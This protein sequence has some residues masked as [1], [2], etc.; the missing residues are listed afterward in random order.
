MSS[1]SHYAMTKAK[2]DDERTTNVLGA[3]AI[4]GPGLAGA[5]LVGGLLGEAP[6]DRELG[7]TPIGSDPWLVR[8]VKMAIA[9]VAGGASAAVSAK[10]AV[11]T[12]SG[13]GTQSTAL[14]AAARTVQG[15]K[16]LHVLS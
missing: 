5:V 11:V 16:A 7:P 4:G 1:R 9:E 15:I 6:R 3:Y 8:E 2:D 12:I 10:D 14:E 13:A